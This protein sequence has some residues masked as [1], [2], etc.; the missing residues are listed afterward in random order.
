MIFDKLDEIWANDKR[1]F[2]ISSNESLEY[3]EIKKKRVADISKVNTGDVVALVGDFNV[4]SIA[5]FLQLLEK[6]CIRFH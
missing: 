4:N 1:P 2:L 6:R 5:T 3:S